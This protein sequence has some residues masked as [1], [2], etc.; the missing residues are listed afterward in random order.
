MP[1]SKKVK[2]INV[3]LKN[4]SKRSAA[5]KP[6]SALMRLMKG[7]QW[8]KTQYKSGDEFVSVN[9]RIQ[10]TFN[11]LYQASQK[12]NLFAQEFYYSWSRAYENIMGSNGY[13]QRIFAM[14]IDQ[15]SDPYFWGWV[16]TIGDKEWHNYW[17]ILIREQ[18]CWTKHATFA[19]IG[20]KL[21]L[22]AI[23]Q[24]YK[25]SLDCG[26]IIDL[27]NLKLLECLSMRCKKKKTEE[28]MVLEKILKALNDL[29][30]DTG[31]I[32]KRITSKD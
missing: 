27:D 22:A 8:L 2:V 20:D 23:F 12:W 6:N 13:C 30:S 5:S 1:T 24:T 32:K 25:N 21:Q 9:W 7:I 31:F 16:K 29:K 4:F 18:E 14:I 15:H 28:V 19:G 11:R 10:S 17:R 3:Q 26:A